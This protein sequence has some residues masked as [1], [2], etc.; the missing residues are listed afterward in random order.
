MNN[1]NP[2]VVILVKKRA[3]HSDLKIANAT[4]P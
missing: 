3:V 1:F 2:Q 4:A